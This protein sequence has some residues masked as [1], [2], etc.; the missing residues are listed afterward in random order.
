LE[1][2]LHCGVIPS[3]GQADY[4]TIPPREK[5]KIADPEV[6]SLALTTIAVPGMYDVWIV[7]RFC[8]HSPVG[9]RLFLS[10]PQPSGEDF[11]RDDVHKGAYASNTVRVE[12]VA[13]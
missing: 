9:P 6:A 8:G 11:L 12:V 5:R 2:P 13:P 10:E 1:H 4:V 7:Y 3:I